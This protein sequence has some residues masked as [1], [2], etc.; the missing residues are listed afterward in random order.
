MTKKS[1]PNKPAS[2]KH[3]LAAPEYFVGPALA[4]LDIEKRHDCASIRKIGRKLDSAVC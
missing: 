1:K 4:Q 2:G 3:L